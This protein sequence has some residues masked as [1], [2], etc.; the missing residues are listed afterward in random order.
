MRKGRDLPLR[1]WLAIA[2]TAVIL[3]PIVAWIG[4]IILVEGP[5][6]VKPTPFEARSQVILSEATTLLQERRA[7]WSSPAFQ[8]ELAALLDRAMYSAL[9]LDAEGRIIYRSGVGPALNDENQEINAYGYH[10]LTGFVRDESGEMVGI[11][12]IGQR[13]LDPLYFLILFLAL[14]SMTLV[15]LYA[16]VRVGR[17]VTRPLQ[18]FAQVAQLIKKGQ[19]DFA[20]PESGV[21]E[22]NQLSQAFVAMRNGLKHALYQQAAMEQERRTLIAAVAHDLRTPLTSVR[23][24][25]EGIRD[26]IGRSPERLDH[27]VGVALEKTG[28]LE[29]MIENLF[30]YT[31]TEYLDQ[32][33]QP[34]PLD[35]TQLLSEAIE[36]VRPQARAKRISL[37]LEGPAGPCSIQGDR[38]MLGRVLD[39]LLD[40]ALRYT[41]PGGAIEVGWA[42]E[43][44][45]VR[46]WV[47][48][49]G[50]GLPP[51][52][53]SQLF[54]PLYR[55]DAARSSHTGGA[56]L[57]LAIAKRLVEAH[58]GRIGATGEHGARF[59]V[60]LPLPS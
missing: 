39:N 16:V 27:Y 32:P 11:Y 35:L 29:Q 50:P 34:E 5:T 52:P 2:L 14:L 49:S 58:G 55:G 53:P 33:I 46:F 19:L 13:S 43:A 60:T 30:T 54:E 3:T 6:K 10:H 37:G 22:L 24:Y 42:L 40:N 41:P 1:S 12:L 28:R 7:D 38:A 59:T 20:L 23:G 25:L 44:G 18:G 15:A 26:G 45:E 31:K 21:R 4:T 8:Q 9:L 56:G 17:A 57:G 48:D 36:S 47:Q 51:V